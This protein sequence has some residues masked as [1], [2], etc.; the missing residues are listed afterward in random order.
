MMHPQVFNM[1]TD[2]IIGVK[3]DSRAATLDVKTVNGDVMPYAW[4]VGN[5]ADTLQLCFTVAGVVTLCCEPTD[6]ADMWEV[7]DSFITVTWECENNT[8][9]TVTYSR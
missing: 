6:M 9:L 4:A 8:R 1:L 3:I 2:K 7:Y 5:S